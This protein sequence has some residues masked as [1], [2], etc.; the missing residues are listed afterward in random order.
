MEFGSDYIF[1]PQGQNDLLE[2][3]QEEELNM[4]MDD[5]QGGAGMLKAND[6]DEGSSEERSCGL[7]AGD[8]VQTAAP[9]P[10]ATTRRGCGG[11][12]GGLAHI[13][14]SGRQRSATMSFGAR[15]EAPQMERAPH[16]RERPRTITSAMGRRAYRREVDTNVVKVNLGSL[17]GEATVATGDPKFCSRCQAYL[18]TESVV[19]A[20]EGEDFKMQW[21]CEFCGEKNILEMVMEEKPSAQSIDYI[22][23][24]A[25][26]ATS[27]MESESSGGLI[28]FVIDTSGSMCISKEVQGDLKLK[29]DHSTELRSLRTHGDD[30]NQRLPN[31]KQEI[32]Y[33]TR[34]QA[35]QAAV[36]AQLETLARESPQ[37]CVGLI[38]FNHEVTVLGDGTKP[39]M[40]IAGDR[41][42]NKD[43]I[44][45]AGASYSVDVPISESKEVLTEKLF[46]IEETGATA[47]G[48]AVVTALGMAQN[49]RGTKIIVCTDGLANIGLG[50]LDELT[51]QE[52]RTAVQ[53]FYTS[54]GE[55]AAAGG[56]MID[57]V[58]IQ[59]D[60]CDLANLGTMAE[61]TNG[62]MTLVD[63]TNLAKNFAGI[64]QNPLVATDVTVKMLLHQG[65]M[66]RNEPEATLDNGGCSV[67]KMV[68][69]AAD[70]TFISFEFKPRPEN[71]QQLAKLPFQVQIRYTRLNGN[72]CIRVLSQTREV[73]SDRQQAERG[74]HMGVIGAHVQSES[75]KLAKESKY[76]RTR[77]NMRAWGKMM[78]RNT[79]T[80]S[81]ERGFAAALAALSP[82]DAALERSEEAEI[83]QGRTVWLDNAD[84]DS[85]DDERRS[86]RLFGRRAA[87]STN[88]HLS[89]GLDAAKHGRM[90]L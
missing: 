8:P 56:L 88:D 9:A 29:G 64:L 33:I 7:N 36:D 6:E 28:I 46:G 69:N 17:G 51:T 5:L 63:I 50:A 66:F 68:G 24:N 48:P 81:Q 55:Q 59:G 83:E 49:K 57:V 3:V 35:V 38:T 40:T 71:R 18:N 21:D 45:L 54:L 80:A 10:A 19:H 76:Y 42:Q 32:T 44:L 82:L 23:E 30:W 61:A 37:I 73:T 15:A 14:G 20:V 58:G 31:E 16:S 34:M 52:D 79:H 11:L 25:A 39:P 43:E 84:S 62:E 74:M 72:K 78:A 67:E 60:N 41:L 75:H 85:D 27:S 86:A 53:A 70:D 77:T 2:V 1:T 47:L 65:L 90:D 4:E 12:F 26:V 22:I 13:F 87:Q 89:A